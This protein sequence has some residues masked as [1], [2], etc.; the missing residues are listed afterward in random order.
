M[1]R[2]MSYAQILAN[3]KPSPDARVEGDDEI[4]A[5]FLEECCGGRAPEVPEHAGEAM[6][7]T[8]HWGMY[9]PFRKAWE[10]A[11]ERGYAKGLDDGGGR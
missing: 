10:V 3:W 11:F 1:P 7:W 4:Y 5:A 2:P 6:P 8:V 9:V